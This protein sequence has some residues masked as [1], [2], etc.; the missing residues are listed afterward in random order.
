MSKR[1]QGKSPTG[2][3]FPTREPFVQP[4][5]G[6]MLAFLRVPNFE[7]VIT[8]HMRERLNGSRRG[9]TKSPLADSRAGPKSGTAKS[10][11]VEG[12]LGEPLGKLWD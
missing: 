6:V 11:R 7:R 8:A 4:T 2:G 1:R 5:P 3:V 12:R 10:S 9:D